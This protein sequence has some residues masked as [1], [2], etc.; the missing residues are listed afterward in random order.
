M[1]IRFVA[2]VVYETEGRNTGPR[3]FTG[4]VVDLRTDLAQRWINRRAAIVEVP[5]ILV[6]DL[7]PPVPAA[8]PMKPVMKPA[9]RSVARDPIKS[10]SGDAGN[11]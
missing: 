1:L 6:E 10:P 7:P 2:D 11:L 8:A 4:D 9:P 5:A 3:Y